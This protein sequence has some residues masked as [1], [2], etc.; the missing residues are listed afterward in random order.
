MKASAVLCLLLAACIAT[1]GMPSPKPPSLS[2]Y[3][4]VTPCAFVRR[5]QWRGAVGLKRRLRLHACM[6]ARADACSACT[7]TTLLP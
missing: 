2:N 4:V 5:S 1:S 3:S 7:R 6:A